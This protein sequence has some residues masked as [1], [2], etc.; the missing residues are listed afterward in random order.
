MHG[1]LDC[2]RWTDV[3]I[4]DLKA[5]IAEGLSAAQFANLHS[6]TRN[7]AIGKANRLGLHFASSSNYNTRTVR[8]R[9]D[10]TITMRRDRKRRPVNRIPF[11]VHAAL[12]EPLRI[13][14]L[15]RKLNQC[16][17]LFGDTP[18]DQ[19]CCGHPVHG[20]TSWCLAHAQIVFT[21]Y[22]A[23]IREARSR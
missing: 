7:A 10:R 12:A 9:R 19:T 23:R 16:A 20:T 8:E 11:D 5:R 14:F 13:P 15:D 3:I 1:T 6:I 4:A 17:R 2:F 18:D 22:Q 21:P